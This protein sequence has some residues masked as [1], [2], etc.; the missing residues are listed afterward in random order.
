MDIIYNKTDNH[1]EI[2]GMDLSV[3]KH[4]NSVYLGSL[5]AKEIR[6]ESG[7]MV[8]AYHEEDRYLLEYRDSIH[9]MKVGWKTPLVDLVSSFLKVAYLVS[10]GVMYKPFEDPD[11][12]IYN[13]NGQ[14]LQ[15]AGRYDKTLDYLDD[16]Y[17]DW[18]LEVIGFIISKERPTKFGYISHYDYMDN[19]DAEH[20]ELYLGYLK[21]KDFE[22]LILY[23]LEPSVVQALDDYLPIGREPI[24]TNP[25]IRGIIERELEE[26]EEL[27]REQ[28]E[29]EERK[30]LELEKRQALKKQ[31]QQKPNRFGLL[32]GN[33]VNDKPKAKKQ[34]SN[35]ANAN[36]Y[37]NKELL[38]QH[39]KI[40]EY[41]NQLG[42]PMDKKEGVRERKGSQLLPT[43]LSI[44][45]LALAIYVAY[46]F[47]TWLM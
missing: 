7:S 24:N 39:D 8:V 22:D 6:E 31:A 3:F 37:R 16:E 33:S 15:M 27:L 28:E 38:L 40:D 4:K 30:R 32:K 43:L 19:M 13:V 2:R 10:R 29:R 1:L 44:I 25:T 12:F 11:N 21:R 9:A 5:Y 17:L 36:R 42:I 20:R 41:R 34:A 35:K 26:R 45:C 47:Y 46:M 23:A 14:R 18:V